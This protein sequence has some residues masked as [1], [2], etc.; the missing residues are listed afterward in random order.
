[1]ADLLLPD[2]LWSRDK[3]DSRLLFVARPTPEVRSAL[4]DLLARHGILATLGR[5]LFSPENWHQ[6]LSAR[7]VDAPQVREL[8]ARAGDGL[9]ARAFHIAFE[10]LVTGQK[11]PGVFHWD[12]RPKK[13]SQDLDRVVEALK[14]QIS[15]QGLPRVEHGHGAHFTLSYGA[16]ASL[17]NPV[18]VGSVPWAVDAVELVVGGGSP[19]RYTTLQRWALEPAPPPPLQ[20]NLF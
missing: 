7:Y 17:P 4:E 15:R 2:A 13:P 14:D 18:T 11:E 8:L 10:R 12:I 9:R 6:S 16:K 3:G 19:Y 1:M 5:Q 20:S